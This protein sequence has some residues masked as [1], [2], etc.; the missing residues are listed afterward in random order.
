[1]KRKTNIHITVTLD[2]NNVPEQ[3][4][5]QA[6]DQQ[7]GPQEC[8]A[9]LLSLF[10]ATRHETLKIDLWTKEMQVIEMDRFFFQSLRAMADTYYKSTQNAKLAGE[11]QSFVRHF[12]EQTEIIPKSE[13]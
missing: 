3:I 13:G 11:M 9:M 4:E 10:D 12:G 2:E 1:M 7:Q 8:K 6:E 5:W